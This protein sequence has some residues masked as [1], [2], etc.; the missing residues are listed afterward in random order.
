MNTQHETGLDE[1]YLWFGLCLVYEEGRQQEG[2]KEGKEGK[3][4]EGFFIFSIV[5]GFWEFVKVPTTR[6][7]P[8]LSIPYSSY[9]TLPPR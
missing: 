5:L 2:R 4:S 1:V 9:A 3:I 6:T 8:H 7:R